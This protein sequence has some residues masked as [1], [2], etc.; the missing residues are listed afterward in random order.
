MIECDRSVEVG[1]G[2]PKSRR[3]GP[4]G[5]ICEYT[6]SIVE[7]VNQTQQRCGLLY[8]FGNQLF[9]SHWIPN[10]IKN[11][12]SRRI[13]RGGRQHESPCRS[14]CRLFRIGRLRSKACYSAFYVINR[15]K[16]RRKL[17][18]HK[19]TFD[20]LG[21]SRQPEVAPLVAQRGQTGRHD[22]QHGATEPLYL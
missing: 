21:D 19:D 8:P 17:G 9:V 10:R 2:D 6:I 16:D 22:A 11:A 3:N 12:T 20:L 7:G 18:D 14:L 13:P 15:P 4:Q 1:K 5:G